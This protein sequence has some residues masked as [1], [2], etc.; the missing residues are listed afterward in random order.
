MAFELP[1]LT[2]DYNALEPHIDATT[3]EIHHTK[4][5]AG[6]VSNLNAA[7]EK[8]AVGST[9]VEDLV[10]GVHTLPEEIRTAVRNHGGG[11]TIEAF[12]EPSTLDAFQK[13]LADRHGAP[14]L[15]QDHGDD[16]QHRMIILADRTVRR[17]AGRVEIAEGCRSKHRGL[18]RRVSDRRWAGGAR[19]RGLLRVSLEP[20]HRRRVLVLSGASPS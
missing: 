5:H 6:Y 18:H 20:G 4:H 8:Y 17:R 3:M 14:V 13:A 12:G 7:L 9:S 15:S 2:Y 11:V 16:V 10:A 1:S 19:G